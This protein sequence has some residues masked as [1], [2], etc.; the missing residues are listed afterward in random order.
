MTP[1]AGF[2]NE[3]EVEEGQRQDHQHHPPHHNPKKFLR[4]G[5]MIPEPTNIKSDIPLECVG[6]FMSMTWDEETKKSLPEHIMKEV[7]FFCESQALKDF[8]ERAG[9]HDCTFEWNE[10]NLHCGRYFKRHSTVSTRFWKSYETNV[11]EILH[12]S[13][14]HSQ[15]IK[16]W[17]TYRHDTEQKRIGVVFHGTPEERI[18][19]ILKHGL[20]PRYR[21]TQA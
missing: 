13:S 16:F 7:K 6:T 3:E 17:D 1:K 11:K 14:N 9:L 10:H 18:P 15:Y 5:S 2:D 12:I 21:R 4:T 20:D 19:D 8:C